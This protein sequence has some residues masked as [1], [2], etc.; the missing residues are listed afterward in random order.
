MS[1]SG[2]ESAA[3]DSLGLG[4]ACELVFSGFTEQAVDQLRERLDVAGVK[5]H[6]VGF[7]V[8]EGKTSS[9]SVTIQGL[10][11]KNS[12]LLATTLSEADLGGLVE[13]DPVIV[14]GSD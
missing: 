10:S 7:T 3:V 4:N 1:E 11:T 6:N 5:V 13:S 2:T 12:Q 14:V 8:E 9:P